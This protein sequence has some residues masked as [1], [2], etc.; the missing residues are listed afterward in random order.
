MK[1]T[2]KKVLPLIHG[3]K[4]KVAP[5]EVSAKSKATIID[6]MVKDPKSVSDI[7]VTPAEVADTPRKIADTFMSLDEI[8]AIPKEHY[9]IIM[10]CDGGSLFSWLIRTVDKSAASHVE[11]LYDTDK[12]ASQGLWYQEFPV[13]KIKS[14]NVKL[15]W[16]PDWTAEQ[17]KCINDAIKLRLTEGKWKT[18]Y[19]VIGV[20]GEALGIKWMQSRKTDFCS[21]AVAKFIRCVDPEFDKWMNSN[22]TP[23]PREINL[24]TKSHNPPYQVYGRFMVDDDVAS[25]GN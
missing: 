13:D 24:Y 16:N 14:Y 22:I 15:I 10:Y 11:V 18:R 20:L 4:K 6:A 1:K 2:L 3:K 5:K 19:D 9:P 25:M 17:R 7:V 21:E 23:T 12:I 8:R